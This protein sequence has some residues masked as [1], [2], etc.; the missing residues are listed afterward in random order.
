MCS[1]TP[2]FDYIFVAIEESNDVDSMKIEELQ[3]SLKAYELRIVD[4]K[5]T[6]DTI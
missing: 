1:L 6:Q 2:Q 5:Y 4:K 3:G